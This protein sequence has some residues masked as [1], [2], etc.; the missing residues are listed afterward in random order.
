LKKL[1]NLFIYILVVVIKFVLSVIPFRMALSLSFPLSR[2]AYILAKRERR[3]ASENIKRVLGLEKPSKLI[4]DVFYYAGLN[5]IYALRQTKLGHE[6]ILSQWVEVKGNDTMQEAYKR[7]KGVVCV[8]GHTGC[9]ELVATSIAALGYPTHVVARSLY[10]PRFNDML[11][12]HRLKMN[13][14]SHDRDEDVRGMLTALRQGGLLGILMDQNT[15]VDS[16]VCDFM[17][18]PARTPTGAVTL[19]LKTSAAIVPLFMHLDKNGKQVLEILPEIDK[20]RYDNLDKKDKVRA[21]TEECN[22]VIG[23]QI[24]KHP[25]QWVWFHDRWSGFN[26]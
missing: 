13:V 20:T 3:I 19:A 18:Y 7:G 11:I 12:K 10:D 2:I 8:T 22:R 14:H 6:E 16:I 4:K 1:K 23:E 26:L 9:W 5:F 25:E 21:L 17:G 24:K 15:R